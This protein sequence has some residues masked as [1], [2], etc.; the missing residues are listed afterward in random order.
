MILGGERPAALC[1]PQLFVLLC[2]AKWSWQSDAD[3]AF[4]DCCSGQNIHLQQRSQAD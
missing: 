1:V 2:Q 4:V 3:D